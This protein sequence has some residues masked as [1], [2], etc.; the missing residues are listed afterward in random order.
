M[1]CEFSHRNGAILGTQELLLAVIFPY[2][3]ENTRT[4]TYIVLHIVVLKFGMIYQ[5]TS[6]TLCLSKVSK[7][8]T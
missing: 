6:E 8:L 2:Q 5:Q 3:V 7:V 4:Y 1:S